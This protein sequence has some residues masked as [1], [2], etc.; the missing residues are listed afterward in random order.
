[1]YSTRWGIGTHGQ[2]SRGQCPEG[3]RS[4]E[5]CV[6]QAEPAARIP[7]FLFTSTGQTCHLAGFGLKFLEGRNLAT[8]LISAASLRQH[9]LEAQARADVHGIGA[10]DGVGSSGGSIEARGIQLRGATQPQCGALLW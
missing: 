4:S 7:Y 1:M 2:G 5:H 3:I 8:C 9:D 10:V 6:H